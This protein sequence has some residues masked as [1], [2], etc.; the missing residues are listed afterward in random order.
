MGKQPA[1]TKQEQTKKLTARLGGATAVL[2]INWVPA[3]AGFKLE[4]S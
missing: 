4:V 2:E 3:P 1:P